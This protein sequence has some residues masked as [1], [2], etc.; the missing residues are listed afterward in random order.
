MQKIKDFQG[1]TLVIY[2]SA[3]DWVE[4]LNFVTEDSQFIQ[5]GTW[6][7]NDG[8]KLD[9][10]RHNRV[11]RVA[12]ITQECVIIM[13]GSMDV[14]IYDGCDNYAGSLNMS[15]GDFAVFLAGGHEYIITSD[16]TK[17]IETKNG[18]FLGVELDKTKF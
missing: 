7:Y 3:N 8:K 10:H 13:H 9:R 11:E 6:W 15:S 12:N 17:I 5:V 16:D 2:H 14:N 1:N 4:G 18:P